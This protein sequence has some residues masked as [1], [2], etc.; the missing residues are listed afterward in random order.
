MSLRTIVLLATSALLA[1]D[2]T[3]TPPDAR[4]TQSASAVVSSVGSGETSGHHAGSGGA[5]GSAA[6]GGAGGS[7]GEG[8]AAPTTVELIPDCIGIP[9]VAV[10]VTTTELNEFVIDGVVGFSLALAVDDVVR[11]ST[12]TDHNIE[13]VPGTPSQFFFKSGTPGPHTACLRFTAPTMGPVGFECDPHTGDGMVGT[14][15]VE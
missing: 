8:G 7:G 15:T 1:C 11:F 13:S 14:L 12:A 6:E 5:G 2:D 4:T 10:D 9:M 3:E